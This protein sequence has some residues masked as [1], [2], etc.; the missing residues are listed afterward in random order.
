M[1]K[2]SEKRSICI[3]TGLV[4]L[5][6]VMNNKPDTHLKLYAGGSC[7]NVLAILSFLNWETF[8]IARLK[9]N[10]ASLEILN[11]LGRWNINTSLISQTNDGSTPIIIQRIRIDKDG[12]SS[13]RFEF[14]NPRQWYLAT[15]I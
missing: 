3:G 2:K 12:N 5:D 10:K 7:G 8:P 1:I 13:H 6:I 11:D 9:N 14:R 15:T 4:A